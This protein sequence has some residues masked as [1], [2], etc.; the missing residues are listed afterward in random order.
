[1]VLV[2]TNILLLISVLSL[3]VKEEYD[4]HAAGYSWVVLRIHALNH[5]LH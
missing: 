1:M 3:L 5:S 4:F 2:Y